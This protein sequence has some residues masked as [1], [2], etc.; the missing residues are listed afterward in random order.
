MNKTELLNSSKS[1]KHR[2]QTV[3]WASIPHR[4]LE[5][6]HCIPSCLLVL[7]NSYRIFQ[8]WLRLMTYQEAEETVKNKKQTKKKP[9]NHHQQKNPTWMFHIKDLVGPFIWQIL[10][11]ILQATLINTLQFSLSKRWC[12]NRKAS[13]AL[14]LLHS[15]QGQSHLNLFLDQLV[16]LL[17]AAKPPPGNP[18]NSTNTSQSSTAPALAQASFCVP[19]EKPCFVMDLSHTPQH[20]EKKPFSIA[21]SHLVSQKSLIGA[22]WDTAFL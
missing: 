20:T 15:E 19:K 11:I 6:G 1:G 5:V 17:L 21:V 13:P 18:Q 12:L 7:S 8:E 10:S 9:P 2:V 3:I 4:P 14:I 22:Y 16:A